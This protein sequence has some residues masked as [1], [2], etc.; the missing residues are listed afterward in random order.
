LSIKNKKWGG[1][2]A[3]I[4]WTGLFLVLEMRLITLPQIIVPDRDRKNSNKLNMINKGRFF[5]GPCKLPPLGF[6]R[7]IL[8]PFLIQVATN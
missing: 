7:L 4:P 5:A 6:Y 3:H 8:N 2:C 1:N